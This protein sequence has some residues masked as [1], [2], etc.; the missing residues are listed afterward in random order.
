LR[1]AAVLEEFVEYLL[2]QF[3]EPTTRV[4]RLTVNL[5]RLSAADQQSLAE[6][7]LVDICDVEFTPPSRSQFTDEL[8]VQGITHAV[9]VGGA[10]RTT[11]SFQPR[12]VREFLVLDADPEGRLDQNVLAF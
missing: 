3:S 1:T 5:D 12:D 6:F 8:L 9:T 10:W 4:D 11:L 2:S 7:E